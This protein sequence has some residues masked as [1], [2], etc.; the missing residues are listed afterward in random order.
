MEKEELTIINLS[1]IILTDN[2]ISVLKYGLSFSPIYNTES[3]TWVK[4]LNLF[5]RKLL[6]HKFYSKGWDILDSE[7]V[8]NSE[9]GS[10]G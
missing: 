7:T 3:F 9:V 8:G 5:C 6:L 1:D 4:D 10:P 2:Q